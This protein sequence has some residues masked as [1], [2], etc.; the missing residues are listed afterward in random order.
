MRRSL[1]A[2]AFTA[3]VVCAGAAALWIVT[4]P[5]PAFSEASAAELEAGGDAAKGRLVFA[6]GDCASC[7]ASPGQSDRLR[8]GGGLAL[9][10]PFGTFRVPNI[11][12]DPVD[13]IGRWRSVDL[14][15]ALISGV[16]PDGRHYYPALP[17]PSYVHMT[18]AD[19]TD[20]MAYLRTLAPVSGRAPAHELAPIFRVRRFVGVWKLF[21]MDRR[22]SDND[23]S[24]ASAARGR[25]L[26]E[27]VAHCAEC[28]S[29]RNLFGAIKPSTRL[30]GGMNPE[31]VGFAPNLT[32][33]HIGNWTRDDLIEL[34]TSGR[35]PQGRR[36]GAAMDGVVVNTA[37]LPP[38]DRAAI[39]DYIKSLPPRPTP[40][41]P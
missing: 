9:A 33:A 36:V 7:H 21:F 12:P 38:A 32:P 30:A 10:S 24:M 11:S 27:T 39:A 26:V 8:L 2:I 31:A 22:G 5:R 37:M 28:H 34:L 15:N 4:A 29:T 23:V 14:A 18:R 40:R 20:L 41:P 3:G 16:S 1:L 6:A 35:T 25:Y 17:Y 13:G 19:V